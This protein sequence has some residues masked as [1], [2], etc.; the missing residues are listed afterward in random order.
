MFTVMLLTTVNFKAL[1]DE[2]A[3]KAATAAGTEN[4]ILAKGA[5]GRREV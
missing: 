4:R 2:T 5:E 3:A 1:T